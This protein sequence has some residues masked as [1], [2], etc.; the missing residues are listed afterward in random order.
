MKLACDVAKELFV[1]DS[2]IYNYIHRNQIEYEKR[3][4]KYW[5][6]KK[7]VDKLKSLYDG[8]SPKDLATIFNYHLSTIYKF[9]KEGKI[10]STRLGN[11][12]FISKKE[13]EKIKLHDII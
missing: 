10:K 6:S 2:T 13:V 8:Y 3:G 12:H 5:I 4:R 7:E 1:H 11:Q 9:I